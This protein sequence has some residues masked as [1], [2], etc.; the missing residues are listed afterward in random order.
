DPAPIA[1]A[2]LS[3]VAGAR[4]RHDD[5]PWLADLALPGADGEWYPAGELLLPGSPLA[6]VVGSDTPFGTV[7]PA[8]L[9]RYGADTLE[10]VGVLSSFSLLVAE[11]V[12]ID[13]P[14]LDLD[15][16]AEWA[17]EVRARLAPGSVPLVAPEVL[18]VRDL[19]LVDPERWPL[20]LKLLAAPSLRAALVEPT[21]VLL[22]DGRYAD[23]PSYTSWWLRGHPVL[24]GRRPSEMRAAGAD[25]LLA[26]LYDEAELPVDAEFARALGL[27]T[28]LAELLA[29]P[30][31]ANE[32]LTRLADP[33]RSVT[34]AQLRALWIALSAVADVE[35]PDQVR[36]V[37]RNEV[38]VA[39]AA[40]ALILD[41]PDLWPLVA[42][43]PLVLAPYY[44]APQLA[45]LLDLPLA[46]EEI[47]GQVESV[48]QRASVPAV[49]RAVLPDAPA[50][51][52]AHDRLVVDGIEV[53]WR[54]TAGAVHA[55]GIGGLAYGLAWASGRWPARHL[56][57]A[58][59]RDPAASTR[60]LAEAELDADPPSNPTGPG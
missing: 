27:R 13:A 49:V 12:A 58:L 7:S 25:P 51:Y 57:A 16:A 48:P 18:A 17:A 45:D 43:D 39:D 60:L 20:A 29:E 35:P 50:E 41:A 59:L 8:M 32:L 19:E 11:D 54:Y 52:Y 56:L 22:A 6:E 2:V 28:S 24:G 40:E 21:R 34:R 3:L 30:G 36:A 15:S 31:G 26:G 37:R 55:A 44:L 47:T 33:A 9:E 38:V 5:Y 23:V 42:G 4:L 1:D 14:D 46:S 10:A 53:P